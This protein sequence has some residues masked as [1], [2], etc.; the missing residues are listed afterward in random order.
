MITYIDLFCGI[1]GF[2]QGIE[3]VAKK[4]NIEAKCLFAADIDEKAATVYKNNYDIDALFDL[5]DEN[6]HRYI[7]KLLK[8]E[9]LDFLFAGFPCQPFSK[10]GKQ[11]GFKDKIKGTLFFEIIR[12]I[13]R[14]KPKYVL[15]E[16]VRNLKNH[17]GGNTW[18]LIRA[19]LEEQGYFV[20]QIIISPNELD[21]PIPAL[22]ERIFIL[23]YKNS[24][25]KNSNLLKVKLPEK[26]EKKETS[27]YKKND[28]NKGLIELFKKKYPEDIE[29]ERI[30]TI[31]MW[32]DLFQLIKS[33][34]GYIISPLWPK[35]F[36]EKIDIEDYPDWKKRIIERNRKFY[37]D[38]KKI[39]DEWFRKHKKHFDSLIESD[40]KFEWNA[41]DSID[42]IWE[43]IIQ[44][45]PSGV[46]VKRPDFIPTLVAINQTPIIGCQKRYLQ[47]DE[48]AKL[49]GFKKL[50]FGNESKAEQYKQ[51]G[52][53][54]SVDVA[55]YLINHMIESTEYGG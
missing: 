21:K 19:S 54:I 43:G 8:K 22:R 6:T 31:E 15:L 42:N 50:K 2:H 29:S 35:Y 20:D 5:Q 47:P 38:N 1:G 30:K 32:N 9:K 33:K 16:N 34:K 13:E 49:Y 41:G 27:I 52:N 51:L 7:N 46:R 3:N 39:Y 17:D 26:L 45:R 40:K 18:R 37:K 28:V 10:A 4:H 24:I 36:N 48:I 44:F 11:E 14:H 53:T 23:A 55:E 25:V 12:I